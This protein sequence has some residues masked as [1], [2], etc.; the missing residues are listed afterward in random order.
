VPDTDRLDAELAAIRQRSDRPL[1]H[2]GSLPISN[3][4]VR[5]LMESCADVPRLLAVVEAA[6]AP[7]EP[8]RRIVFG[9]LC[10]RH[11]T[12]R[13]FSITATEAADVTGC[14]DCTAT[15]YASCRACG[16][17]VRLDSCPVREAV[18]SE[19]LSP[20]PDQ[21]APAAPAGD[22][23]PPGSSET[24]PAY[25]MRR[26]IEEIEEQGS[27]A[28]LTAAGRDALGA[29]FRREYREHRARPGEDSS[30]V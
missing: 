5:G 16:D 10:D 6:L 15:V 8:G 24:E 23:A 25:I 17:H 2:V 28:V 30:R 26:T 12:H 13:F 4:A 19:L 9:S 20:G 7:H 14:P 3:P 21:D 29:R 18:A 27:G 1:D 22:H 11:E